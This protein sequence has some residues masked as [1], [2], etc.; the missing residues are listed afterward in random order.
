MSDIASPV[1]TPAESSG[2]RSPKR[3]R[4]DSDYDRS[5]YGSPD[6]LGAAS[7]YGSPALRRASHSTRQSSTDIRRH[8][9][10]DPGDGEESP[11]ELDHTFYRDGLR[12]N[13]R[14][15][16]A[17]SGASTV[18]LCDAGPEPEPELENE[19]LSPDRMQLAPHLNIHYKQ[20]FILKGH[21]KGVSAVKFSP[22]G[23]WIAS[24]WTLSLSLIAADAT[25]KIWDAAT[26]KHSQTLEGHLAGI[27]TI[28]WS[29]DSKTLASGSDDKSIRLWD[30]PTVRIDLQLSTGQR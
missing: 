11:D 21:T 19:T 23:R 7:Y 25:I 9:D 18:R 24:C 14:R 15:H 10:R 27:S 17:S 3:R 22:D 4:V 1:S 29:P 2:V 5:G 16:S 30:I 20:K 6:E 13:R 26:G 12:R 8:H 28:A